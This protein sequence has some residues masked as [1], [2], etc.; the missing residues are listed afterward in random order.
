M[1]C[2]LG[3]I[4]SPLLCH[5]DN[6]TIRAIYMYSRLQ[7]CRNDYFVSAYVSTGYI[8]IGIRYNYNDI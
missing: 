8:D 3:C 1:D 2:P 5:S 7:D 6:R 4:E